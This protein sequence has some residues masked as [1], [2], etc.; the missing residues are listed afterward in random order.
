MGMFFADDMVIFGESRDELLDLLAI[1]T[2]EGDSLKLE[3]NVKKSKVML[4][5]NMN[6]GQ[7]WELGGSK[8]SG[9]TGN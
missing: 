6:K 3:F 7:V 4:S 2:E 1:V 9:A 8:E 5:G